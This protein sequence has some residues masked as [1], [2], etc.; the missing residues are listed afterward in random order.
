MAQDVT[1]VSAYYPM[2]SKHTIQEYIVWMQV[3][4]E[5]PC[6][7]VFFTPPELVEDFK[8]LRGNHPTKIIGMPFNE[9]EAFKRYG[10]DL[11]ISQYNM[12]HERYH[13]PELYAIWYEKKEFVKK[14]I[15]LNPF[16]TSKFVWCDAG[17]CRSPQWIP[18]IKNFPNADK[19]GD[20]L[21]VLRISDFENYESYMHMDCVGG[22]I[23]AGSAE[24]WKSYYDKYDL[25]IREYL[26]NGKFI[27]KDQSIIASVA[28]KYPELFTI[29]PRLPLDDF[30]CWFS[31]FFI[32]S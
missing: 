5:L 26:D 27:G 14:A 30:T 22:T 11:W 15:D 1:V 16:G 6:N 7:L 18:H 21:M 32:L 23:L 29:V 9:L 12:D 4:N 17:A 28:K 2:K 24:I 13:T 20:K 8:E 25:M 3:W 31:L 19:I 10:T